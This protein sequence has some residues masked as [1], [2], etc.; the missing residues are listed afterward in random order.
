MEISVQQQLKKDKRIAVVKERVFVYGLIS[1]SMLLFCVFYVGVNLNSI[2]LAFKHVD[3]NMVETFYGFNNFRIVLEE[4][5]SQGSQYFVAIKNSLLLVFVSMIVSLPIVLTFSYYLYKKA[6]FSSALRTLIVI[7]GIMSAVV[8]GLMTKNFIISIPQILEGIG[9]N[10]VPYLLADPYAFPTILILT[11][12]DSFGSGLILVSN[13]MGTIDGSIIESAKMDGVTLFQEIRYIVLPLIWPTIST[14]LVLA[15]AGIF[16]NMGP[17]YVFYGLDAP[18][19][20]VTIGYLLLQLTLDTG[21][22]MYPQVAALGLLS[23]LILFPA[24]LLTKKG[25]ELLD[26]CRDL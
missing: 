7:P 24:T 6:F 23:T 15:I 4:I 16:S 13:S 17:V 18:P 11:T 5:T 12:W 26:P 20:T 2:L 10:D 3:K 21:K 22:T 9:I 14:F 1:Y 8:A 19:G 25:L